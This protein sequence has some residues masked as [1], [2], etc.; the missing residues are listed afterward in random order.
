MKLISLLILTALTGVACQDK[1]E[2]TNAFQST[3][4]SVEV[5]QNDA[6]LNL[7]GGD[8]YVTKAELWC[9]GENKASLDFTQ[10]SQ[11]I[12]LYSDIKDCELRLTEFVEGGDTYSLHELY[13]EGVYEFDYRNADNRLEDRKL[14]RSHQKIGPGHYIQCNKD[15]EFKKVRVKF[16]YSVLNIEEVVLENTVVYNRVKVGLEEEPAPTCDDMSAELV[17]GDDLFTPPSL[18]VYLEN[19]WNTIDSGELEFGLGQADLANDGS[20]AAPI[21]ID[22]AQDL[23]KDFP[24]TPEQDGYNYTITLDFEQIKSLYSSEVSTIEALTTDFMVALRNKG[25]I[26]ALVYL[27]DNQCKVKSH[28]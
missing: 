3:E 23:I 12:E 1:I 2:E 18:V 28:N 16:P 6:S 19:C 27:I 22:D 9:E 5:E 13:S 24:V 11:K 20:A 4:L 17:Q 10:D 7:T 14:V 25:G 26:S 15:C 21:F 8:K